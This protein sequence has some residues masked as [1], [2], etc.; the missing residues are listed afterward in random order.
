VE[1]AAGVLVL[2]HHLT[3]IV[4]PGGLRSHGTRDVDPGE[5]AAVEQ[6]TAQP[7]VRVRYEGGV[8]A[9][10]ADDL[11]A[12]VDLEGRGA[13]AP[14]TANRANRPRLSRT[15]PLSLLASTMYS[16]TISPRLLMPIGA[17]S[18]PGSGTSIVM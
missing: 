8:V 9:V 7:G 2:A 13:L 11:A 5:P 12:I 4:D 6:E 18:T 17:N 1:R 14:G 10:G 3:A 15:K 16:P